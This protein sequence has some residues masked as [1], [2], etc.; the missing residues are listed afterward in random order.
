MVRLLKPLDYYLDKYGTALYGI[1][2]LYLLM[3]KQHNRGQ[4]GVGVANVKLGTEPGTRYISRVRSNQPNPIKDVFAKINSRFQTIQTED[5]E[6]LKN[7]DW[8]QKNTRTLPRWR[9]LK[10]ILIILRYLV[11]QSLGT[12]VDGSPRGGLPPG[13][14]RPGARTNEQ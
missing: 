6:K 3:E 10:S 9:C 8:L 14:R 2:K 7:V 1:N 12:Y 5:P 13:G 4:D 11:K